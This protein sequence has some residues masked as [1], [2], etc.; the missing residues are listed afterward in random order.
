MLCDP[1]RGS[2]TFVVL[3]CVVGVKRRDSVR[4]STRHQPCLQH[5]AAMHPELYR[6][7]TPLS[8]LDVPAMSTTLGPGA[9]VIAS[10][11]SRGAATQCQAQQHKAVAV[12][13]VAGK[14]FLELLSSCRKAVELNTQKTCLGVE[15]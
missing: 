6:I 8:N 2:C 13:A 3:P 11:R 10:W 4:Y 15:G 9:E 14:A 12:P 5:R 7:S 1:A